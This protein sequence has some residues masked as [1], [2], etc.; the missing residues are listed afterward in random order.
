M[1]VPPP[2]PHLHWVEEP[3]LEDPIV[4]AAFEGWSD[5]GGAASTAARYVRDHFGASEIGTIEAEDFFDFTVARP[6]VR[7][8]DGQR[9]IEWP[10]TTVH[11]ARLP[12]STHDLVVLIGHEPQL[13][14]RTFADHVVSVAQKV[15][16]RHVVTL[17]ALLAD[18]PHTRPVQVFG[19]TD[20]HELS[21]RLGLMPSTYEGPT[22][23]VGVLGARL[24]ESGL[25]TAS[26]W[27]S[28]P[29]YVSSAPSPKAALALVEKIS[30]V[31]GVPLPRTDLEIASEVYEREISDLVA[32]DERTAEFVEDLEEDFDAREL[33]DD[34]DSGNMEDMFRGNETASISDNPGELVAEVEDF[35]RR[36]PGRG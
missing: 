32:E 6:F 33:E 24:R 4:L 30:V 36:H 10:A 2:A 26:I 12:D 14:W 29:A 23:I 17:G 5:A 7:L 8:V 19:T 28:V 18:V 35:L 11:V 3:E 20:N 21:D 16:A 34:L 1:S 25:S 15:G 31:L 22:G 27:A 13:R 9:I